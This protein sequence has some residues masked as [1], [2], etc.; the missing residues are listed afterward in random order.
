MKLTDNEYFEGKKKNDLVTLEGLFTVLETYGLSNSLGSSS[1][2][3]KW[4]KCEV[5]R[6]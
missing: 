5:V 3:T 6:V 1:E 4:E 2:V